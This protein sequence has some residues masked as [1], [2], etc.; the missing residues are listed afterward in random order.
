MSDPQTYVT[1]GLSSAHKVHAAGCEFCK[2]VLACKDSHFPHKGP[3]TRVAW[4]TAC[5][6]AA[7]NN[8]LP[9]LELL[10]GVGCPWNEET[11]ALAAAVGSLACLQYA[12]SNG[13]LWDD[14]SVVLAV[15]FLHQSCLEYLIEHGCPGLSQASRASVWRGH[16]AGLKLAHK[17]GTRSHVCWQ[18]KGVTWIAY[19]TLTRQVLPG[20]G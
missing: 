18:P 11:C 7:A 14:T 5:T 8:K 20:I 3:V 10:H 19:N 17:L 1:E 12:H 4:S 13:C 6:T 2:S 16:L 15:K 9:C